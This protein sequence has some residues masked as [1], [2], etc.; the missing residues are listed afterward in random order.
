MDWDGSDEI[1]AEG[2]W[3][4]SDPTAFVHIP[5]GPSAVRVW[6]DVV[7]KPNAFLWRTISEMLYIEDAIGSTWSTDKVI[8]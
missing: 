1:V 6:V 7:R 5:I 3:P 8:R 2:C 4:S